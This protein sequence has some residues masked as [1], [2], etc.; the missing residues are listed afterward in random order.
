[1]SHSYESQ[2]W[3]TAFCRKKQIQII[4]RISDYTPL[5]IYANKFFGRAHFYYTVR[6]TVKIKKLFYFL[7]KNSDWK[8]FSPFTQIRW[9]LSASVEKILKLLL[10]NNASPKEIDCDGKTALHKCV[11][12]YLKTNSKKFEK[13]CRF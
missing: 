5:N 12:Q 10:D 8:L 9:N 11:E 7:F 13:T 1:M 6:L 4:F 2:L 3:V